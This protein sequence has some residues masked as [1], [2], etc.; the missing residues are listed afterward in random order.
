[1]N[2]SPVHF[3]AVPLFA[4]FLI[5]IVGR[6]SKEAVKLIPGLVLLYLSYEI[7]RAHV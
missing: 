3:I 2:F 1:M 5:P 6:F 4:A 7:G